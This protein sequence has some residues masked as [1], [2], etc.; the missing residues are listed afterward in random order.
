MA[1][2]TQYT[3]LWK[4]EGGSGGRNVEEGSGGGGEWTTVG[5]G[6][7][8]GG[9][10][11]EG[12]GESSR[13][14]ATPLQV[15]HLASISRRSSKRNRGR[16]ALLTHAFSHVSLPTPFFPRLFSN[17]FLHTPNPSLPLFPAWFLPPKKPQYLPGRAPTQQLK[18]AKFP[19]YGTWQPHCRWSTI[20]WLRA[21]LF[22]SFIHIILIR[23]KSFPL[24]DQTFCSGLIRNE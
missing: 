21:I 11:G 20:T 8:E 9:A 5:E 1:V 24:L 17:D 19:G 6:E 14:I 15:A 18:I 10:G 13:S 7:R 16:R 2:A 22:F 12:G 23:S 4:V 3:Y